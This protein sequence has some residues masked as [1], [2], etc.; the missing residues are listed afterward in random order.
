MVKTAKNF[1]GNPATETLNLQENLGGFF[2]VKTESN[3]A[4]ESRQNAVKGFLK[5]LNLYAI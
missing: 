4:F 5:M 2:I 1:G 3:K